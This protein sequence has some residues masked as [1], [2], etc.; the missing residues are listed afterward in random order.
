MRLSNLEKTQPYMA[1]RISEELEN[2]KVPQSIMFLGPK[3]SSR[4][5]GAIELGLNL[6][7]ESNH[8][9]DLDVS[10]LIILSSRNF[11]LRLKALRNLFSASRNKR[12]WDLLLRE[13]RIML[14]SCHPALSNSSDKDLFKAAAELSDVLL[15][16]QDDM[17]DK[18]F[19]KFLSSYDKALASF[20]SSSKKKS[21]FT[22][23]QI[24]DVQAFLQLESERGKVVIFEN[25]ED[26]TVGAMN[27]LLKLLEEPMPGAHLI[28]I[29][30]DQS[31][32]LDTILS[33]VRKYEFNEIDSNLT[34]NFV[35]NTFFKQAD[36]SLEEF[37]YVQAGFDNN[38]LIKI[39][40]SFFE[41]AFVKREKDSYENL[42]TINAFLDEFDTYPLFV[43]YLYEKV[44]KKALLDR[45]VRAMKALKS[46]SNIFNDST[47][48]N[49]NKKIMIDRIERSL[50]NE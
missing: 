37:F 26:V 49:Q 11:A 50:R 8:F 32:I 42:N 40:N 33:R 15:T 14:L 36:S 28:L 34:S 10:D 22:I 7:N 43:K 46:L 3:F 12:S 41:K 48:Y 27:S 21:G 29:S 23:D 18:T 30:Q 5:T 38:Q 13:T 44:E 45:D 4:M 17:D 20:F 39:V 19:D 31:R 16:Y 1:S 9:Q 25:I 24:R 35:I 2:N 47:I 6:L